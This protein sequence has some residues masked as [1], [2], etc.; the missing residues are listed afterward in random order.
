MAHCIVIFASMAKSYTDLYMYLLL[1]WWKFHICNLDL[2]EET[3]PRENTVVRV[4]QL[5]HL[6][7]KP[8]AP[9]TKSK[10]DV[11]VS[12]TNTSSLPSQQSCHIPVSEMLIWGAMN[13]QSMNCILEYS[14]IVLR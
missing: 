7:L 1:S 14:K 9:L 12:C 2:I 6:T 5:Y 11:S 3:L 8:R 4:L 13:L 10:T